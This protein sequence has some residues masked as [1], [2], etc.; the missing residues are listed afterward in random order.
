M[1]LALALIQNYFLKSSP[2]QSKK[3]N[4]RIALV[5]YNGT[6]KTHLLKLLAGIEKPDEG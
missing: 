4:D 1:E 3:E 5:G 2:S 6:G